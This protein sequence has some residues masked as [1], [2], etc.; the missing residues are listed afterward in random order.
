[1]RYEECISAELKDSIIERNLIGIM[2][3]GSIEQHGPHL[4]LCVDTI[5][6]NGI[7]ETLVDSVDVEFIQLPPI[8]YGARSLSQS[9]GIN[10]KDTTI[11]VEG[12]NLI[13][14]F[15]DI[16]SSYFKSG[17]KTIVIVNGHYENESLLFEAAE[18]ISS[19]C[20]G[21]AFL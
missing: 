14:Y 19:M 10:A 1:M 5:I 16:F 8:F 18:S 13:N 7:C 4:P 21:Q 3:V 17:L 11:C 12:V 15:R 2:A 20:C 9:G 6:P